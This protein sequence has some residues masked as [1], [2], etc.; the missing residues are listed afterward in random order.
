MMGY[1]TGFVIP[2]D[3]TSTQTMADEGDVG[4]IEQAG[5]LTVSGIGVHMEANSQTLPTQKQTSPLI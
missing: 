2:P 4:I 5:T 3:E 1:A